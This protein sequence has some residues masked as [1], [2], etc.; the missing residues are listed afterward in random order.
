MILN[1]Q[2]N[3]GASVPVK[4]RRDHHLRR[5]LGFTETT[6]QH[7]AKTNLLFLAHLL[8][9]HT[10]AGQTVLDPMGG[11]GSVLLAALTGHP[12]ISGDVEASWCEL[13]RDNAFRICAESLF[14]APIHVARWDAGHLPLADNTIPVIITSPPYFDAFSDWNHSAGSQLSHNVGPTGDCYGFDPRQIANVHVYEQYL[15]VMVQV[16]REYKRVLRPGGTLVLILGDKVHKSNIVP[17][18]A[19][20]ETL[21]RAMGFTLAGRETRQ[22]IPSR[23]RRIRKQH[24]PDYPLIETET[25]LIFQ[26]PPPGESAYPRQISIIQAPSPNNSPGQQLYAKQLHWAEHH[27]H[28]IL[29]LNGPA[30]AKPYSIAGQQP[31]PL[32]TGDH[33]N[34]RRRREWAFEVVHDLVVLADALA[35]DTVHLH[36]SH[37]YAPYLERRLTTIGCHVEI[38]T[39]RLNLG[40]KLAWYT[41]QNAQDPIQ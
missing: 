35:R 4:Y 24:D 39:Q 28:L 25:A 31:N 40:Q 17:V 16:Y 41:L 13:Q 1:T 11:S 20:N 23:Y 6:F 21:C 38:P 34:A 29:T 36:V 14:C 37:T 2:I 9:T 22:T 18:T 3:P 12:V 33:E 15:K 10:A 7:H 30:A 26:K 27:C 8:H 19:D 32:W 5:Y